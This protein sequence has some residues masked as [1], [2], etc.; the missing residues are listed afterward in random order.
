ME[1]SKILDLVKSMITVLAPQLKKATS[2]E[3]NKEL[4]EA[5]KGLL[6]VAGFLGKRFKDGVQF[7]DFAAFYAALTT[8]EEFKKTLNEAWDGYSKI[9]G[10]VKDLD[11][12]EGLEV[13]GDIV[14]EVPVLLEAFKK[15]EVVAEAPA[16]APAAPVEPATEPAAPAE[17]EEQA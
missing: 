17:G 11:A 4:R 14:E 5:V 16:E 12:G 2:V 1:L 8:D 15:E 13:V 10:E 9:S 6:K 3:G 7:G